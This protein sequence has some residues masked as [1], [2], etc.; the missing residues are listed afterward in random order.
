M[1]TYFRHMLCVWSLFANLGLLA[2]LPEY[3][4]YQQPRPPAA[5]PLTA[6]APP[7]LPHK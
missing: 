1:K 5:S 3:T 2:W 7:P 6:P 4:L